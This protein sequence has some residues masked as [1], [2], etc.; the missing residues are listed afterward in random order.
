MS[1]TITRI[2]EAREQ[3][4]R[5][6][7]EYGAILAGLAFNGDGLRTLA[8]RAERADMET[9]GAGRAEGRWVILPGVSERYG[10]VRVA[11]VER[12][13][14]IEG[15]TQDRHQ[16]ITFVPVL[17]DGRRCMR[18]HAIFLNHAFPVA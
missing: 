17:R 18:T 9:V 16:A 15:A 11:E 4:G 8:R 7:A 14:V 1:T 3:M 13:T 6:A 12:A 10:A 2:Q 5:E